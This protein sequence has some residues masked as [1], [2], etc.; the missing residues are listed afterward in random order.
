MASN[1]DD[2]YLEKFQNSRPVNS[3]SSYNVK[4]DKRGEIEFEL[5]QADSKL[6][7]FLIKTSLYFK[8]I[9]IEIYFQLLFLNNFWFHSKIIKIVIWLTEFPVYFLIWWISMFSC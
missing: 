6:M 8:N 1:I 3:I 5:N 9:Y 7:Y 4:K 2:G